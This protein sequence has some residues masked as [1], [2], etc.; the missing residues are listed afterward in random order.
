[1][2][3][4]GRDP[5]SLALLAAEEKHGITKLEDFVEKFIKRTETDKTLKP[6]PNEVKEVKSLQEKIADY[7]DQVGSLRFDVI[8]SGTKPEI[9][10]MAITRM[11]NPLIDERVFQHYKL[12]VQR[13]LTEPN[14]TPSA[15]H[16]RKVAQAAHENTPIGDV[17]QAI[18]TRQDTV[19]DRPAEVGQRSSRAAVQKRIDDIPNARG[20]SPPPDFRPQQPAPTS[21]TGPAE[22]TGGAPPEPPKRRG[23]GGG[24]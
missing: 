10:A 19:K 3:I 21:G 12:G 1:M 16:F 17:V 2:P 24:R 5:I 14:I 13:I 11:P 6:T 23:P 8:P 15:A 18:K 20:S 4:K 7:R 22:G 9:E